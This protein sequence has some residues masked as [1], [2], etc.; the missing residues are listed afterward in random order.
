MCRDI[1]YVVDIVIYARRAQAFV[2]ELSLEQFAVDTIVQ[3]ATFHCFIMMGEAAGRL[4]AEFRAA[5]ASVAWQEIRGMRNR[6]VHDYR[7]TD[8]PM[9]W[10]VL[11]DDIPALLAELEPLV[12]PEDYDEVP[13]EWEFL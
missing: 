10:R 9:V 3:D 8:V 1:A 5:H 4:S 12:P 13:S 7:T 11:T 6:L 2:H